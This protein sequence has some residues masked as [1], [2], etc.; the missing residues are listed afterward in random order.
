MFQFFGGIERLFNSYRFYDRT[1]PLATPTGTLAGV[2]WVA[3]EFYTAVDDDVFLTIGS[4]AMVICRPEDTDDRG[5]DGNRD[6]HRSR[7]IADIKIAGCDKRS[8]LT[9]IIFFYADRLL[10]HQIG[11]SRL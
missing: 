4:I 2:A 11:N 10:V 9:Q 7:I 6:V 5:P 3:T 1:T 8:D